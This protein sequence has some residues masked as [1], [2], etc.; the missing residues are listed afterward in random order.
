MFNIFIAQLSI[1][2]I[3][4]ERAFGSSRVDKILFA[5]IACL[6]YRGH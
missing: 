4:V 6:K 1:E 5:C 2:S 3:R